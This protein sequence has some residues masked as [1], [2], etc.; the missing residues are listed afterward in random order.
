MTN[1]KEKAV[2]WQIV[3][4]FIVFAKSFNE[5][6]S[7]Y[8]IIAIKSYRIMFEQYLYGR[9]GCYPLAHHIRGAEIVLAHDKID[10][11]CKS[12]KI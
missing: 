4:L 1:G 6:Y 5:M 11:L 7:F 10:F 3:S 9:I 2:Y 8:T 12:G